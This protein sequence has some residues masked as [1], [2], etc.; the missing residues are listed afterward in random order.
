M[1]LLVEATE[2]YKIYLSGCGNCTL[3]EDPCPCSTEPCNIAAY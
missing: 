2:V 3:M 1:T